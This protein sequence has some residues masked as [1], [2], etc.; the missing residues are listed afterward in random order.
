MM[1]AVSMLIIKPVFISYIDLN[2]NNAVAYTK[3][4]VMKFKLYIKV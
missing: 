2:L 4:D 3:Y 1:M